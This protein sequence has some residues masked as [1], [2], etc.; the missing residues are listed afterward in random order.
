MACHL[1]SASGM[2]PSFLW[3][4]VVSGCGPGAL[5][6]EPAL[7]PSSLGAEADRP[8]AL[9]W[10]EAPTDLALRGPGF[11][12]L[13]D[14]TSLAFTRAG[15]FTLDA[16]RR[17]T[18]PGDFRVQGFAPG[19]TT[20]TD[21]SIPEVLE[22]RATTTVW[23]A[24]NLHADA[25]ATLQP[26]GG[27]DFWMAFDL[28]DGAGGRLPLQLFFRRSGPAN[29]EVHG[30]MDG[31]RLAGGVGGV[32]FEVLWV[33]LDFDEQGRLWAANQDSWLELAG[34]GHSRRLTLDFSAFTQRDDL[35]GLER[36]AQDGFDRGQLQHFS[37]GANGALDAAYS[38]GRVMT[39]AHVA[40]ATFANPGGLTRAVGGL[41]LESATSGAPRL[42]TSGPVVSGALE[43]PERGTNCGP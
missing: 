10:T 43:T 39:L 11:F 26:P 32:D 41:L 23:L 2:R 6:P 31:A 28:F 38:N 34:E 12:A 21:V 17:L 18:G 7:C 15:H 14:G 37:I 13:S 35:A 3:L 4:L 22:S 40:T 29:W 30:H 20:L 25:D 5:E 24:G 19:A 42:G 8:G 9:V 1:L 33:T 16:E 27:W 36:V